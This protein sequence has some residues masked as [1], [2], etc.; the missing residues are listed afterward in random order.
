MRHPPLC[1]I[2]TCGSFHTSLLHCWVGLDV[3]SVSGLKVLGALVLFGSGRPLPQARDP[4]LL[5]LEQFVLL[6]KSTTKP[7]H[8]RNPVRPGLKRSI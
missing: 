2:R 1:T 4:Q 6:P 3:Q 7:P 5:A 8:S